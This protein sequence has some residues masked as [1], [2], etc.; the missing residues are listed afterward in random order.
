MAAALAKHSR[1]DRFWLPKI[2]RTQYSATQPFTRLDD[3]SV[4]GFR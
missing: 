3:Q 2:C 4:E 1:A